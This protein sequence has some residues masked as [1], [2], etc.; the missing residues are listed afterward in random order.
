VAAL[1]SSVAIPLE[2]CLISHRCK[3]ELAST[4]GAAS[5]ATL[6]F[7]SCDGRISKLA[8]QDL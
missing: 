8:N 4:S 7:M 1:H 5:K 3:T 6:E 2:N